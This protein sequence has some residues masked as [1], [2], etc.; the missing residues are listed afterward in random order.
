MLYTI[1]RVFS[2]QRSHTILE[3]PQGTHSLIVGNNQEKDTVS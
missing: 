1:M 2:C 3:H